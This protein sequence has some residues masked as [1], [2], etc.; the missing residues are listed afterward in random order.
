MNETELI[1]RAMSVIGSRTSEAKTATSR[2]NGKKGGRPP[3]G[4]KP[5]EALECR[6]S[7]GPDAADEAHKSYCPRGRAY[8]RRQVQ[9]KGE[10]QIAPE[11]VA[12]LA[13]L[14][15]LDAMIAAQPSRR[16][17]L[18]ELDLSGP[19]GDVYGYTE[20]EDAQL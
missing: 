4:G 16:A 20:R 8:R 12:R 19:R 7:V 14:K 6:C 18:P 5:L 11:I 15:E 2:F 13:A 9:S 17:G 10:A 1:R 3:G